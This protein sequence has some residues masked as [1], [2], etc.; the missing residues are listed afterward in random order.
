MGV[1]VAA[2]CMGGVA[3][4]SVRGEHAPM[5]KGP[6]DVRTVV[7]DAGVAGGW[8]VAPGG[9]DNLAANPTVGAKEDAVGIPPVV[10]SRGHWSAGC[11]HLAQWGYN[12]SPGHD[13]VHNGTAQG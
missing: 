1:A 6:V 5:T 13:D 10:R 4:C 12:S 7:L 2:D 3:T 9:Y 8:M 11:M